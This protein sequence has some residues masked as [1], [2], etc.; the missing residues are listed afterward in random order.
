MEAHSVARHLGSWS[1][2]KGPLQHKL[3]RALTQAIRYGTLHPGIRLPSERALAQ[4]LTL[5]RTTV[6]A[7]YD[8][9][10]ET[11]WLESRPGSGTWVSEKS[12]AI[13]G[14]REAAQASALAASPLLALL[15]QRE[16]DDMLDFALGSPLP[17][18]D[19]PLDLFSVPPDEYAAL[20]RDRRYYPLGL[21]A[22]REA[23]A[24]YYEDTGMPTRPEQ[25]LVTNGSQQ[26]IALCAALYLQRGDSALVEDPAYFG[27]LDAFRA[28]G[29][30]VS[31]LPV[32]AEGVRPS[33]L[34]DR[35]G[36]TAA[37]LVYL[38]PSFQNPT[39]A[40]M[41]KAARKEVARIAAELDVPVIDDG[42][43]ADL[44][45]EGTPPPGIAAHAPEAAVLTLGSLS[46]LLWP[47]LRAGWV[48]ATE[49]IIERLARVRSAV[50][51][52]SPLVTQAIAVR[53]LGAIGEA[54]RLRREE[55]KPRRDL[56]AALLGE[57]LPEWS[58]RAPSGGLFLWVKLPCGDAREFAQVTLRHGVVI[59]PGPTMSAADQH[60]SY[61]R[62][63]FLAEPETLE[64]GIRRLCAAW[65]D[66]QSS[67]RRERRQSMT[68]V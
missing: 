10:R 16:D 7:A 25:I 8:A 43:L 66:Y 58:F 24:S 68:L 67:D 33:V 13:S 4:A 41:P 9:L 35:I 48:R 14:A 34:R 65:R 1:T 56:L 29:A 55:L 46:K 26:A 3:A 32:D 19:L 63:P 15:A 40:V 2:G 38:T 18:R 42:T 12:P 37:R 30:R 52:G 17:L 6:V 50:D 22:L 5:S 21:R 44:A 39:G 51:L 57:H 59:L 62:L 64:T 20:V 61:L 60:A 45:L 28:A 36:A 23:I 11:G 49:P 27:A 53:L 31:G 47:G 54:R